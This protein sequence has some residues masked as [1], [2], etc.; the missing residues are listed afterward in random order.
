MYESG[1]FKYRIK[2]GVLEGCVNVTGC[3]KWK[4]CH[5]EFNDLKKV[6]VEEVK[7]N[8][9]KRVEKGE[10]YWYVSPS[11]GG[12]NVDSEEEEYHEI[13]G[14]RFESSNYFRTEELALECAKYLNKGLKKFKENKL[15]ELGLEE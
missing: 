11:P 14:L 3:N 13:D 6:E 10:K 4:P 2:D 9:F 15:K 5:I 12:V 7:H 8:S 1:V